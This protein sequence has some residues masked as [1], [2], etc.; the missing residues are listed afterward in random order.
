MK[1]VGR[2]TRRRRFH[3]SREAMDLRSQRPSEVF[4]RTRSACTTCTAT[5]GNGAVIVLG[6]TNTRTQSTPRGPGWVLSTPYAAAVGT[7]RRIL[8]GRDIVA[9]EILTT[10]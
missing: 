3:F 6:L 1:T 2:P 9:R 4:N 5:C 7:T 8:V 10:T